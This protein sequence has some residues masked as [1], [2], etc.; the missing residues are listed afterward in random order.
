MKTR[1][2]LVAVITPLYRLPLTNDERVSIRHLRH[3]LDGFDR[4]LIGPEDVLRQAS[5]VGFADFH[6]RP[7][8]KR[9]FRTIQTYSHLLLSKRFY[10]AF[11][12]YEYIL[13]YQLDCL[14]FSS[15]LESW[16]RA[17][18]DY[19]GAP[20]FKDCRQDTSAGFWAV[21][22]GGFSLRKV[23]SALALLSKPRRR[24][25]D[26]KLRGARTQI[27]ASSPALRRILVAVR[28]FLL[29]IGY[30]NT[31]RWLIQEMASQSYFD[32]DL[33]WALHSRRFA[34][35]FR[36]A[37]IQEALRFSFE[38]APRYCFAANSRQLPFG[39]HAWPKWDRAFWEPFLLK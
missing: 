7:F 38:M 6:M 1:N 36:I 39:C 24:V 15:D 17:G 28:T 11:A 19:L 25:D 9:Y 35:E 13:I 12:A 2:N 29:Q 14:V 33:F 31:I 37:P 26:P 21:G 23:S 27:F 34:P 4:F 10:E 22:N 18:W 8:P 30:H 3:H 20:W 16:C 5:Q 32:E